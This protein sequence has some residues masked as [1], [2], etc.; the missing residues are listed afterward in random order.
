M[1]G[2]RDPGKPYGLSEFKSRVESPGRPTWQEFP[3]R[4]LAWR[5]LHRERLRDPRKVRGP[6]EYSATY[7]PGRTQIAN[8]LSQGKNHVEGLDAAV[9]NV[10]A[11]PGKVPLPTSQ[12]GQLR[13]AEQQEATQKG[14]APPPPPAVVENN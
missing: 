9:P 10:H 3:A 1:Q 6:P 2:A 12:T 7:I 8:C 4:V 13:D 11:E 5:E 14:P